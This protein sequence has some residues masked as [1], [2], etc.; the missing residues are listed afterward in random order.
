MPGAD[1]PF[2]AATFDPA[3]YGRYAAAGYDELLDRAAM[4]SGTD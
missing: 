1:Q 4:E 3:E 2:D